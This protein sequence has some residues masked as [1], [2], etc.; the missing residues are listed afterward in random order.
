M[1]PSS[2]FGNSTTAA[3]PFQPHAGGI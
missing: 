1:W 2:F 3:L